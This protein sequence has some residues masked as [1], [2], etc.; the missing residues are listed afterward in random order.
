MQAQENKLQ[1]ELLPEIEVSITPYKLKNM[2][3][4]DLFNLP[5]E[6]IKYLVTNGII[7]NSV[8]ND[9]KFLSFEDAV[10]FCK[11]IRSNFKSF[12]IQKLANANV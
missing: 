10:E 3:R 8:H 9:I 5:E 1:D 2:V 4:V 12:N 6:F 11:T 7:D